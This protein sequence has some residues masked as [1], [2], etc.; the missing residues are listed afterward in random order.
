MTFNRLLKLSI[1]IDNM[2]IVIH[3]AY[4]V[5]SIINIFRFGYS[6]LYVLNIIFG[7]GFVSLFSLSAS[8]KRRCIK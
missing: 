8:F 2:L 3:S 7:I 1:S 5:T 4:A 6:H